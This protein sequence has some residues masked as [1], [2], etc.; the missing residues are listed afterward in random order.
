MLLIVPSSTSEQPS[1]LQDTP[2]RWP[3]RSSPP[4]RPRSASPAWDTRDDARRDVFSYLGYYNH[5]R[6][7]STLDYHAPH[8][9]RVGYRQG[10]TLVA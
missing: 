2:T 10:L 8:E 3:S 6:L 9:V 4:S 1:S 5:D 7:H